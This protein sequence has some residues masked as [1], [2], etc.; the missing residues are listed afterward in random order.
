M[1]G[2]KKMIYKNYDEL[3][4]KVI[5]DYKRLIK[6]LAKQTQ[7]ENQKVLELG[8]GTGNLAREI[9]NQSYEIEYVG[10]DSNKDYLTITKNKLR[11]KIS[12]I[13][14]D[15][16]NIDFGNQYDTVISSLTLHHFNQKKLKT[17]YAKIKNV[18]NSTGRFVNLELIKGENIKEIQKLQNDWYN[19]MTRNGLDENF[20]KKIIKE[21]HEIST[22]N[23]ILKNLRDVGFTDILVLYEQDNLFTFSAGVK[24]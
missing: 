10:I 2:D 1:A 15:I 4:I 3:T 12:L 20:T 6:L 8:I 22:K 14:G 7:K 19:F 5:P 18:L 17:L 24:K 23:M 13:K 21:D 11:K 9:I 16:M